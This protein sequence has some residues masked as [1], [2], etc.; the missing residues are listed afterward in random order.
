MMQRI[1][2]QVNCSMRRQL[3][4]NKKNSNVNAARLFAKFKIIATWNTVE[5]DTAFNTISQ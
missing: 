2:Y 4:Y 1:Q 5:L 3:Y